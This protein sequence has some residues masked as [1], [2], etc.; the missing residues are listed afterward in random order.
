MRANAGVGDADLHQVISFQSVWLRLAAKS[1]PVRTSKHPIG[2]E[3]VPSSLHDASLW[4]MV[5]LPY[6]LFPLATVDLV[7]RSALDGP[8]AELPL[9]RLLRRLAVDQWEPCRT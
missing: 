7:P 6:A 4:A 2:R 8:C 1:G 5:N 3:Y 9:P